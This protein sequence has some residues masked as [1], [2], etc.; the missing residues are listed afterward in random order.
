MS[1]IISTPSAGHARYF[2][3]WVDDCTNYKYCDILKNKSDYLR[4]FNDLL[5][6][7][8]SIPKILYSYNAGEMTS[9]EAKKYYK[10]LGIVQETCNAGEHHSNRH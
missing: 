3:L 4:A 8:P 7:L 1:G 10:A 5:L 9:I 2:V 6:R